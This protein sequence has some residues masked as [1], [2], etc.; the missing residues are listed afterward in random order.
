MKKYIYIGILLIFALF[1]NSSKVYAV[2]G[3]DDDYSTIGGGGDSSGGGTSIIGGD[4]GGNSGGSSNYTPPAPTPPTPATTEE[5]TTE[6]VTTEEE[7]KEEVKDLI[8]INTLSQLIITAK[9]DKKEITVEF[10]APD[11]KRI[12]ETDER[13]SIQNSENT[14]IYKIDN[15]EAGKWQVAYFSGK[16]KSVEFQ[17]IPIEL[18]PVT[19]IEQTT[20]EIITEEA[21]TAEEVITEEPTTEEVTTEEEK[22]EEDTESKGFNFNNFLPFLILS[23]IVCGLLFLVF[24]KV[25]SAIAAFTN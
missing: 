9:Y 16:N 4:S 1:I 11:G 8:E 22:K 24:F 3:L 20:E 6:E 12:K 25:K 7:K 18:Q 21:T 2:S 23:Y 17:T 5:V 14:K 10:V 15:A 19:E 13:V